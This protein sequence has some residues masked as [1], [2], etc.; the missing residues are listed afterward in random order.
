MLHETMALDK[1]L[2]QKEIESM[3][4]KQCFIDSMLEQTED[5]ILI[6]DRDF[7]V[8]ALNALHQ[9]DFFNRHKVE[10]NVGDNLLST[11]SAF[12]EAQGRLKE[13]INE[14]LS[15]KRR[16]IDKYK[17]ISTATDGSPRYFQLQQLPLFDKG[18]VAGAALIYRDITEKVRT[19]DRIEFVIRHTANLTEDEFFSSLTD[20]M[21]RLFEA[22]HVYIG[23][24][25]E[26]QNT[27]TTKAYRQNG[28]ITTNF[29]YTLADTPDEVLLQN[30]SS[31][32]IEA[33]KESFKNDP[34]FEKTG[35]GYYRGLPIHSPSTGKPLGVFVMMHD[36]PLME[37][38]NSDYLFNVITLRAGAEIESIINTEALKA[39]DRQLLDIT[40]N[41]P[42][43]IYEYIT[44]E[45][46]KDS[47]FTFVSRAA[48]D[49]YETTI[50]ELYANPEVLWK[51]IHPDDYDSF[52]EG[53]QACAKELKTFNWT[54]RLVGKN[55]FK[56]RWVKI[57]AKPQAMSN[58]KLK[59]HGV[60]DDI[61][62]IKYIELELTYAK[63]VA[64]DSAASKEDFL[65]IMS[66]EIRTPLN[67]IVGITDIMI[68][69]ASTDQMEYLN[70]LK[71]S[72]ENL[73]TLINNILDLSK[74][75][76]GKI[77]IFETKINLKLLLKNL[78][79]AHSYRAR[80]NANEL[81]F[82]VD[83]GIPDVIMGDDM[84][85]LQILNNL[86]GNAIKFTR[87]G[88][89]EL[90]LSKEKETA[91]DIAIKFEVNDTGIGISEEDLNVIF[92]KFHQLGDKTQQS[93]GTGLGLGIAK[94]LISALKS[95]L[96]VESKLGEGTSFYFTIK[97]KKP[98]D[99]ITRKPVPETAVDVAEDNLIKLLV[100]E[101]VEENREMLIRFLKKTGEYAVDTAD[102]GAEALK[103]LE[104]KDYDLVLM[105]LRM[106]VMDGREATKIIRQWSDNRFKDLPVIA[107]TADSFELDQEPDF[108]DVITKP[109]SPR[110]L[111][112]KMQEYL[113]L[114]AKEGK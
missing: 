106:P 70:L 36:S 49:I 16:V 43:V 111:R 20:Q 39:H 10:L 12:P 97:F 59:W 35:A 60:I 15:G 90:V 14:A 98:Q 2:I 95:E 3:R 56:L 83:S 107:L 105:D 85:I 61:S 65:A 33:F 78:K 13:L 77:E 57:T 99:H 6:V 18:E 82:N 55:S 54:G 101:D 23:L 7:N 27:I 69:E 1:D 62:R 110:E 53:M 68:D 11:L 96:R 52:I 24:L 89:V 64:E 17:S 104:G 32:G 79:Q 28:N 30:M 9:K 71:F 31:R 37:F 4:R 67:G 47:R 66:H 63:K 5:H 113:N 109:F 29:S 103:A 91:R 114:S 38:S 40:H 112:S 45:S 88:K 41:V 21:Y 92:D 22:S 50:D 93:G 86:I 73:M 84:V 8:L 72:A 26:E 75:N 94:M 87:S 100:V 46:V 74:L 58:G 80:E 102:N 108:T 51:S 42:E 48:E 76:A 25:D 81:N 34:K 44:D 19:D